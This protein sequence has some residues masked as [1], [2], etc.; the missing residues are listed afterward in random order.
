VRPTVA[1]PTAE[2][3][4]IVTGVADSTEPIVIGTV[5]VVDPEGTDT[6]IDPKVSEEEF[7][8][9]VTV[10]PPLGAGDA[11]RIVKFSVEPLAAEADG[12]YSPI[13]RDTPAAVSVSVWLFSFAVTVISAGKFPTG[14]GSEVEADHAPVGIVTV[15]GKFQPGTFELNDTTVGAVAGE[16]SVAVI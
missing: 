8:D 12:R 2:V 9:N 4:V 7:E 14:R 11:S 16:L 5:S 13:C 6:E 10:S 15:D 1:T 3:A